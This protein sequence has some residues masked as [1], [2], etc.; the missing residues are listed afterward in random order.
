[1]IHFYLSYPDREKLS[2]IG[3]DSTCLAVPPEAY[4]RVDDGPP[5]LH[6]QAA[7][8]LLRRIAE[9]QAGALG[10]KLHHAEFWITRDSLFVVDKVLAHDC[11]TCR[12]A[13]LRVSEMMEADPELEMLVGVL[14]WAGG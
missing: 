3:S 11:D 6:V 13:A 2:V 5:A 1:M 12:A 9:E 7:N 10:E 14:Y 8:R 4:V